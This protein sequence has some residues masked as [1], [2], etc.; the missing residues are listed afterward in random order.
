MFKTWG[1]SA[2]ILGSAL[3]LAQPQVAA[4]R[5]RDDYRDSRRAWK[6]HERRER[7]EWREHERWERRYARGYYDRFGY[8]HGY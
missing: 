1:V 7:K 2:L 3:A 4:A 5:D 8:W 6:Q